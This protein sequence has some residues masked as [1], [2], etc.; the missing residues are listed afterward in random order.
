MIVIDASLA[1]DALTD[2]GEVGEAAHGALAADPHWV[3]PEHLRVEA[4]SAIRGRWLAGKLTDERAGEAVR[5]LNQLTISYAAW[6]ELAERVWE[7]RHN[8][9]PYDAA[10]VALA[11]VRGCAL[12][13]TDAK[14]LGCSAHRCRIELVGPGG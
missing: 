4:T 14:L 1:V 3:A 2:D 8:L 9:T 6:D 7:L 11:E 12:V 5:T 10:Y 13:T